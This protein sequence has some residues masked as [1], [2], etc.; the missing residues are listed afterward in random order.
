M[1][2]DRPSQ[3]KGLDLLA[4]DVA[5]NDLRG[6]RSSRELLYR[7]REIWSPASYDLMQFWQV[8]MRCGTLAVDPFVRWR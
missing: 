6:M 5:R 4:H 3:L 2:P 8:Q 1:I 7:W